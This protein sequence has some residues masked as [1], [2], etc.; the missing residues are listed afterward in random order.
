MQEEI[1][2]TIEMTCNKLVHRKGQVQESGGGS[3][4]D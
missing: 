1:T 4:R 2:A 3:W